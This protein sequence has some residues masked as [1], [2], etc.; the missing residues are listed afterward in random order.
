MLNRVCPEC[1]KKTLKIPL[2][3]SY[4]VC[5][6]CVSVFN[7][8]RFGAT[9]EFIS[10]AFFATFGWQLG[11]WLWLYGAN[12]FMSVYA[13]F[14]MVLVFS[15]FGAYIVRRFYPLVLGGVKG[16]RRQENS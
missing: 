7:K 5:N 9:L 12:E 15:V 14:G 6:E 10:V 11:G 16:K 3:L 1:S 8:A 4:F 2:L 13:G